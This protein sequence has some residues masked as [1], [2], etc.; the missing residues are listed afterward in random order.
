MGSQASYQCLGRDTTRRPV[1]F[2]V[3]PF[4]EFLR[5]DLWGLVDLSASTELAPLLH[6]QRPRARPQWHPVGGASVE[7]VVVT[8]LVAAVPQLD[9]SVS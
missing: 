7:E 6:Y 1:V 9:L 5:E 2:F 3:P 4:K 8:P